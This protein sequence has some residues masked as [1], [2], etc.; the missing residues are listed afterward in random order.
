VF[1][2]RASKGNIGTGVYDDVYGGEAF[3]TGVLAFGVKGGC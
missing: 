1:I 2:G 3:D